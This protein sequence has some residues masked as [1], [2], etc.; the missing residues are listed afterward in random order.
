MRRERAYMMENTLEE[1]KQQIILEIKRRVEDKILE[2]NNANLLIKLINNAD[3]SS[4]A[5]AIMELGNSYKSTGLHYDKRLETFTDT[6]KYFK[7]N[8]NLS[9]ETEINDGVRHKLIIG[10]NYDALLNL[11]IQYKG[12]IDV[13]YIDP[14]YG[15]DSMGEFAETN[16]NNQLTRDNLLSM[17]EPRLQLAKRLL[18]PET[19]VIFVSID[20]KNQPYIKCLMDDVFGE[21]RFLLN[22][23]RITKKG[24]KST[25][26]IA[27]NNDYILAYALSNDIIF[28]QE[29]KDVSKYTLE[30]EFVEERGPYCLTQCLDYNSLQYSEGMDF[31]IEIDGITYIP[32]GDRELFNRRHA[33]DHGVHDWVWRWSK[34]AVEWGIEQKMFFIHTLMTRALLPVRR[35]LLKRVC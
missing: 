33:G 26:T 15:K 32:G 22:V 23:P 12:Q 11:L 27:K 3:S 4:E 10:D 30:D 18:N 29:E 8:S 16:Y 25:N 24:G 13:I 19:G 1:T 35:Q 14:P 20:D 2:Q 6:I 17:L 31:E 34:S 7:F 9:F 5:F 28:S 21:N